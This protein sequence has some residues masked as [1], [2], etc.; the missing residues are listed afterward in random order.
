MLF[1]TFEFA[2][3]F[4]FIIVINWLIKRWDIP[5]KVFLLIS[6][7][8]FYG[9]WDWRFIFLILFISLGT[10]YFALKME[11]KK[12]KKEKR[13]YLY[14]SLFFCLSTLGFYKYLQFLNWSITKV[15]DIQQSAF[16]LDYIDI[17]LPVGIS[18]F[19]FQA[20]SYV[21]DIYRGEL[22][23]KNQSSLLDY[24]VYIAFFPQLVAGPIVRAKV[25][26]PQ[27]NPKFTKKVPNLNLAYF[28]IFSGLLKKLILSTYIQTNIVKDVMADPLMYSSIE[29]LMAVYGF[30]VQIYCD[31]SGYSDMAIGVALL[32]GFQFPDNFNS[33]YRAV[34]IQDFWRRWHIS[35]STWLRDYLYIP[36]GGSRKGNLRTY[37]N[38]LIT[39]LLGGLWHGASLTFLFWGA[40]HGLALTFHKIWQDIKQRLGIAE[41]D[42]KIVKAISIFITF[43][44]V[45]ALWVFFYYNGRTADS[46][47]LNFQ[48]ALDVFRA[49]GNIHTPIAQGINLYVVLAIIIGIGIHFYGYKLQNWYLKTQNKLE[50]VFYPGQVALNLVIL[51]VILKMS[52]DIVPAFIYF[53][54]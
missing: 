41:T 22:T 40:A 29:V 18:F 44:F 46:Q 9:Y 42:N 21:I 33:P 8:F 4:F 36:L 52:P 28:L 32:M 39:M 15:F 17:A 7:Y 19:T 48:N 51:I 26:L 13:P 47:I 54:F 31:F 35:L 20:M 43:H 16:V 6:S 49:V 14:Y 37:L 10:Y 24:L 1:P 50:N 27:F 53:D 45:T 25:F 23:N 34:N 11:Q 12:T 30:S 2:V 3:F 38:L 5:W